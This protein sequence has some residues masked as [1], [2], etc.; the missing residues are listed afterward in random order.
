[1]LRSRAAGEIVIVDG[2]MS[3]TTGVAPVATIAVAA[4]LPAFATVTISSAVNL[5][6]VGLLLIGFV[7]VAPTG[8]VGLV[9]DFMRSGASRDG[10]PTWRSRLASFANMR[11]GAR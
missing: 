5:L 2:A 6:I 1:M 3:T 9:Q 11:P 7:I 8:I 10:S 4:Y